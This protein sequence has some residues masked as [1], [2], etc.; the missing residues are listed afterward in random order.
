MTEGLGEVHVGQNHQSVNP[1][2]EMDVLRSRGCVVTRVSHLRS[3]GP[4]F[5]SSWWRE[6]PGKSFFPQLPHLS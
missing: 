1:G 3:G 4:R 6:T 2:L 5:E